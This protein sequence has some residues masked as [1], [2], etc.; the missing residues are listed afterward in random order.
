MQSTVGLLQQGRSRRP[1]NVQWRKRHGELQWGW[2]GGVMEEDRPF[3]NSGG[4]ELGV[5]RQ[6]LCPE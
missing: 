3:E 5:G 1:Q 2:A 4:D 6:S